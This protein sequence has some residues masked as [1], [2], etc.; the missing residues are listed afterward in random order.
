MK[1]DHITNCR[2]HALSAARK[3]SDAMATFPANHIAQ[4]VLNDALHS[5]LIVA[6]E[7]R[8]AHREA[9]ATP[10]SGGDDGR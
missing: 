1:I 5:I 9:L 4:G 3:I 7:T 10:P 8:Q 6:E 2:I